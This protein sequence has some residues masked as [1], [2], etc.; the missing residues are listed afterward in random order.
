MIDIFNLFNENDSL[1][2]DNDIETR[3]GNPNANFL[4]ANQFGAPR[5]VRLGAKFT[6]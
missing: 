4:K 2:F 1:T 5:N 6:W 3:P